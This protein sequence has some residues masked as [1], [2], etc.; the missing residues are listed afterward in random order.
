MALARRAGATR[1]VRAAADAARAVAV[2]PGSA[3]V[4]NV[5]WRA[6]AVR[7]FA[8]GRPVKKAAEPAA[9]DTVP[10]VDSV[11]P[12][13]II[14][15]G[16]IFEPLKDEAG[17]TRTLYEIAPRSSVTFLDEKVPRPATSSAARPCAPNAASSRPRSENQA[18]VGPGPVHEL[19]PGPQVH[20]RPDRQ[21][22]P[23]HLWRPRVSPGAHARQAG[24]GHH[25]FRAPLQGAARQP[26]TNRLRG[27]R[28]RARHACSHSTAQAVEDVRL[29]VEIRREKMAGSTV[30]RVHP[31]CAAA[32][33]AC[34]CPL[35]LI[36]GVGRWNSCDS[37]CGQRAPSLLPRRRDCA[38]ATVCGRVLTNQCHVACAQKANWKKTNLA[39]GL[40][41]EL[42]NLRKNPNQSAARQAFDAS[43]TAA[44]KSRG[45]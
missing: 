27:A 24:A 42:I 26:S 6:G 31:V 45:D 23:D 28:L 25:A 34:S 35:W 10:G 37:T 22:R 32:A 9:A 16:D 40:A 30:P 12:D 39:N 1:L 41:N 20:D 2:M 4:S 15:K 19:L 11:T 33:C 36:T 43:V 8:K 38:R 7:S 3:N 5:C 17:E 44:I 21:P 13:P 14:A 18:K 29:P